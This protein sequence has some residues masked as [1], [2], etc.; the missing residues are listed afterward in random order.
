MVARGWHD[1]AEYPYSSLAG[2]YLSCL[3][4]DLIPFNGFVPHKASLFVRT[5]SRNMLSTN[6]C[7][8]LSWPVEASKATIDYCGWY[9]LGSEP[10]V[11]ELR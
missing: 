7:A 8:Q 10:G 5:L 6:P 11:E 4:S 3:T 1:K 2:I 9:A